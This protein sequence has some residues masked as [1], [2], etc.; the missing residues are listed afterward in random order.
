MQDHWLTSWQIDCPA[1]IFSGSF[2]NAMTENKSRIFKQNGYTSRNEREQLLNQSS[3]TVWL[4]GLSGSG[5]STLAYLLERTL[6]A[7]KHACYVLDGDNLRHG[8]NKD[9][10]FSHAERTENIRRVA[11]IARLLN[12]AGL[13]V[14]SAFISPYLADREMAQKI[15]GNESFKLIHL[16]T[17]LDI[18]ESRDVKGLYK[19]AREGKISNFTGISAPYQAPHNPDL[20]FDTSVTKAEIA[21]EKI[22]RLIK[23]H[24]GNNINPESSKNHETK[25]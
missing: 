18:C 20:V 22:I 16:N 7:N 2:I 21:V 12:D 5:K 11:E 13:I 15:I 25:K 4:T 17:P 1:S 9:L 10:G 6:I 24:L 8:I 19:S 3:L 14:I 23:N